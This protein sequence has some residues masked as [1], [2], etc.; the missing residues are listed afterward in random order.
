[1]TSEIFS[2]G[3]KL[4]RDDQ[5]RQMG[6]RGRMRRR[7]QGG[8]EGEEWWSWWEERDGWVMGKRQVKGQ[9]A[10]RMASTCAC[11]II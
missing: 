1:M 5:S 2:S 4:Q 8:R 7:R 9:V 11:T 3:W 6:R 10:G